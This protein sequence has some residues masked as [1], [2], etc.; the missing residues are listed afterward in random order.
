MQLQN[1]VCRLI[2]AVMWSMRGSFGKTALFGLRVM[3]RGNSQLNRAFQP[4]RVQRYRPLL[5]IAGR[6]P[7]AARLARHIALRW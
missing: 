1:L 2:K 7:N 4:P 5:H 3:V 6:G